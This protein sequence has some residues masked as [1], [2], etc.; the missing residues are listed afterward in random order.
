MSKIIYVTDSHSEPGVDNERADWL[1]Q[2]IIDENP[3]IVI[4]GGDGADMPS[5][6]SYDKGKRLFTGR[7]YRN[8][9]ESHLDFQERMWGPVK[10]RKKKL[11]HRVFLEGN[12]EH[13]IERALDL[14]PELVGTIGFNDYDLDHYYNEVVRYEGGTPGIYT[15]HGISFAHFFI[16]GVSGK[17][18]S[19]ETPARM[20]Y[21]KTSTSSI[22][23]HVHTLDYHSRKSLTGK[24]RHTLVGG[25]YHS[26]KPAWAGNITNLWRE[27]LSI[28]HNVEDGDFDWQWVSMKSL[29]KA[30]GG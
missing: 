24:V 20:L 19:G 27:G 10:A 12:H 3:D 6:S 26:H 25:C 16:T 8:D 14:S 7:S 29:E 5:L 11:P 15:I 22:Q 13:R 23:G 18:I 1:A 28:L 2:L 9:I 21:G 30:Y 4:H 17:S